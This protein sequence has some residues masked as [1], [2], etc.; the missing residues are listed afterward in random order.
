[1][2]G[3]GVC[4]AHFRITSHQD[5][6]PSPASKPSQG[7]RARARA[8]VTRVMICNACTVLGLNL[9]GSFACHLQ[10]PFPCFFLAGKRCPRGGWGR[11]LP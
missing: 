3:S 1:M 11:W 4:F 5:G 10:M 6:S 2:P 9:L 7:A 8:C